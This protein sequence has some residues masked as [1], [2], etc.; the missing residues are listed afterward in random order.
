LTKSNTKQANLVRQSIL[1]E[2]SP[3]QNQIHTITY[4]NGLEFF[5]QHNIAQTLSA[6][7]FFVHP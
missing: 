4:D 1:K 5:E 2:L 7:I 3:H 6:N